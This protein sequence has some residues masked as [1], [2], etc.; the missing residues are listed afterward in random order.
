VQ[1]QATSDV[2][3]EAA[4]DGAVAM[5][6][7]S[8]LEI[9]PAAEQIIASIVQEG[10][11]ATQTPS[12]AS[13]SFR[14]DQG[15][16]PSVPVS[17]PFARSA[18]PSTSGFRDYP[19]APSLASQANLSADISVLPSPLSTNSPLTSSSTSAIA[20][21]RAGEGEVEPEAIAISAHARKRKLVVVLSAAASAAV[22]VL[23]IIGLKAG[24]GGDA[25]QKA[26]VLEGVAPRH[27]AIAAA[28]RSAA[29]RALASKASDPAKPGTS[30]GSMATAG[31]GATVNPPP[32][33]TSGAA[34]HET[35]TKKVT[36]APQFPRRKKGGSGLPDDPG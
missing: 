30:A 35:G 27:T 33:G 4:A 23:I 16:A 28:A 9:G 5:D 22:M 15:A 19:G 31:T 10:A 25:P 1:L 24:Q 3:P 13:A 7:D 18:P 29:A 2:E 6:E 20:A 32:T 8:S 14:S 36:P 12:P 34:P 17:D 21:S 26:V 11:G